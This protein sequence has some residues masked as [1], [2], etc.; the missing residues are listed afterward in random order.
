MSNRNKAY[1]LK[2]E[3]LALGELPQNLK[4]SWSETEAQALKQEIQASNAKI[5]EALPS[6]VFFKSL[7][8]KMSNPTTEAVQQKET[9][10]KTPSLLRILA[11]I[12]PLAAAAILV[13]AILPGTLFQLSSQ[14]YERLKGAEDNILIYRQVSSEI[15]K[16]EPGQEVE[17][18]AKLQLGIYLTQQR[19]VAIFSLDGN[20][21]VSQ[22]WPE[23]GL[24]S[25]LVS[26]GEFLLPF[27]YTL[28][29]APRFERFYLI[30]SN[31]PF[32]LGSLKAQLLASQSDNLPLQKGLTL[33][34]LELKKRNLP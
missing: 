17:A 24:R 34:T 28:D 29:D 31:E 21:V 20:G 22:H 16:L 10:K 5:L 4:D 33:R 23:R 27:S 18:G 32:T 14:D 1:S 26:Q 11:R 25:V 6:E 8:T 12:A 30:L 15:L 9:L 13:L 19:Q 2:E 7:E 3:Q